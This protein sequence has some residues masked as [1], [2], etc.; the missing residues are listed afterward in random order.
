[1]YIVAALKDWRKLVHHLAENPKLVQILVSEYP[2][3]LQYTDACILGSGGGNYT[4]NPE[5]TTI[6]MA[7]CMNTG[8]S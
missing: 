7:I 3:D 8:D 5:H 2:N 1:M 6:D 4:R